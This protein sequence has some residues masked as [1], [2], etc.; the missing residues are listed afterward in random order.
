MNTPSSSLIFIF[1]SVLLVYVT[2]PS[3]NN[4]LYLKQLKLTPVDVTGP[5][6]FKVSLAHTLI[7]T[8]NYVSDGTIQMLFCMILESSFSAYLG[9]SEAEM[10]P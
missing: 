4:G 6:S 5:W 3:P 8:L 1:L 7:N 9:M 2:P 10:A